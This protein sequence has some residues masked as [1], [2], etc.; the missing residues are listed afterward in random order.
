MHL[1]RQ[2]AQVSK[3]RYA[4]CGSG[5]VHGFHSRR[6]EAAAAVPRWPP[7]S[8]AI[9]TGGR[10]VVFSQIRDC[11]NVI[12]S[13]VRHYAALGFYRLLLYLDDCEDC[14]AE[15]LQKSGWVE[16]GF[17]ELVPV[18]DA[19][20]AQW[21]SMPS[22]RRV[23]QYAH[24]EVQSRQIL[25]NEHALLRARELGADWLL[26]IDSDELLCL[27]TVAPSF[28]SGLTSRGC[29]MYTFCNVEGV[30]SMADSTDV[31]QS[32]RFFRQ[33]MGLV[34][35]NPAAGRAFFQWQVRLGGW[36][37]SY[38]NGKTAVSVKHAV[39]CLSVCMWEARPQ[40]E[41]GKGKEPDGST[42]TWFTNNDHLW[43][44]AVN[45]RKE[46]RLSEDE[47]VP[48]LDKCRGAVL[49]HFCVCD[50]ASFWRKR[51]TQL[52][53]LSASDQFRVRTSSGAM[54]A[55]F[56]RLQCNQRQNEARELFQAMCVCD[57]KALAAD[58]AVG[59]LLEADPSRPALN[60]PSWPLSPRQVPYME[61]AARAEAQQKPFD[62]WLLYGK[63]AEVAKGAAGELFRLR[64]LAAMA[65]HLETCAVAD[66][67]KGV[68]F[69][70]VLSYSIL[71]QSLEAVGR[72]SEAVAAAGEGAKLLKGSPLGT[73][74]EEMG[75]KLGQA[76]RA[77]GG[78]SLRI[79]TPDELQV[80]VARAIR[81]DGR[82]SRLYGAL[83][84]VAMGWWHEVH[85]DEKLF[86]NALG[87]AAIS[88][89]RELGALDS[90]VR[91][92][93]LRRI[94]QLWDEGCEDSFK[95]SGV[96]RMD[97]DP[98]PGLWEKLAEICRA[99]LG[100]RSEVVVTG[101]D[102]EDQPLGTIWALCSALA[103]EVL[104]CFRL[105]ELQVL[106]ELRLLRPG[107]SMEVDNGG[108][109]PDNRREVSFR[110]FVPVDGRPP[111]PD[112]TLALHTKDREL[113]LSHTIQAGRAF[114]WWS[115][116]TF[117]QLLGGDGYFAICCWAVV[118]Q[119]P[120]M[121]G[122]S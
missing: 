47:E 38:E 100:E 48:R 55:R 8:Q 26:H 106:T 81:P 62:A 67:S 4:E 13:F 24:M 77:K 95:A 20:R 49:L 30:P 73:T 84:A 19:L 6:S 41:E 118:L 31:L 88:S 78:P 60:G 40:L 72:R 57:A 3:C 108:L 21:P 121:R 58:V 43:Q 93:P 114:A 82:E 102:K 111:G 94:R 96:V 25:N 112:A 17:V 50:F 45:R 23:G 37:I 59:I 98:M 110:F 12:E 101:C 15:V 52:G 5:P 69:G 89:R 14:A 107:S 105:M 36:F 61:L 65:S 74:L 75:R 119:K 29:T 27:P 122:T 7:K 68:E 64:A 46:G 104:R 28:F 11:A 44:A 99:K 83:L 91:P 92:A 90:C 34:P 10:V 71:V 54:M 63:A 53:Y 22:W 86:A 32:V 33:N 109:L 51:W 79:L 103:A 120:D 1:A 117:H 80:A 97:L 66:A 35:R 116:Q 18:D 87:R 70:D 39:K 42:C 56:Y 85:G 9:P 2:L 76:E 115:R 16:S 113:A